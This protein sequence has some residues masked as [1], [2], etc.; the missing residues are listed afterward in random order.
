MIGDKSFRW[1]VSL[2]VHKEEHLNGQQLTAAEKRRHERYAKQRNLPSMF[3][4]K[5]KVAPVT[6][7]ATERPKQKEGVSPKK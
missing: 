2:K 5:R 4:R 1:E 6:P 3:A 7:K